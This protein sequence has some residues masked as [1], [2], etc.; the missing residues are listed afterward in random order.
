MGHASELDANKLIKAIDITLNVDQWDLATTLVGFG[1]IVVLVLLKRTSVKRFADVLII[2][3]GSVVVLIL[4]LETVEVVG[5]FAEIPRTFPTPKLPDLT[6]VPLLAAGAVAAGIVGLAESSGVGSAYPNPSGRRSSMTRDF[7]GQGLGNLAGSFFQA[8]PAGG[9]LSRTGINASGGTTSRWA[10]VFA[11]GLMIVFVL[12]FGP[13]AELIPMTALAA[14]LLVIGFGI[15]RREWPGMVES[16]RISKLR[17]AAMIAV[18]IVGVFSD[19]TVAIFAG[20]LLSVGI[21]VYE[22]ATGA[23]SYE[24]IAMEEGGLEE[25]PVREKLGSNEVAI[26]QLRGNI[27]FASVYSF[28]EFLPDMSETHNSVIIMRERDRDT[29]SLTAVDWLVDHAKRYREHG[30]R[31]MFSRL[32]EE[33][34]R[35][36][37]ELGVV[38]EVGEEYFFIK[39]P[40]LGASTRQAY[41]AAEAWVEENRAAG[42]QKSELQDP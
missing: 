34:V 14:L 17:S 26:I 38:E 20:V 41:E 5:D 29:V 25:R 19:L 11:G 21:F 36:Y 28:E 42:P 35:L 7:G 13:L 31:L 2:V 9:S 4:S 3:I 12:L 1:S 22:A 10:G 23:Q 24:I 40:Q 8:M 27:Y 16:W 37:R 33:T 32:S 15:I 39:Q 18:I 6:L 30:N